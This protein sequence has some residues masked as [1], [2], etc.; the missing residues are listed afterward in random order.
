[1]IGFTERLMWEME[2][3]AAREGML[4]TKGKR[5]PDPL[6]LDVTK[7]LHSIGKKIGAGQQKLDIA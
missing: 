2:L 5:L 4:N 7:D 1:M 3:A 6:Q